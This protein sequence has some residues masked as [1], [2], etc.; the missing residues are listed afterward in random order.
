MNKKTQPSTNTPSTSGS[1]DLPV[2]AKTKWWLTPLCFIV[3]WSHV[4]VR[5]EPSDEL[6]EWI[7]DNGITLMVGKTIY[8]KKTGE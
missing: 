5:R 6:I 7:S 2:W 3:K 8:L 4:L 1:P